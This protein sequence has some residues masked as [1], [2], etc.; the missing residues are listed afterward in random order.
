MG[1]A[2][3]SIYDSVK[4]F[5]HRGGGGA[6]DPLVDAGADAEE[7]DAG[8][9]DGERPVDGGAIA[10]SGQ[11]VVLL[12]DVHGL[13]DEEVVVKGYYRVDEG[14]E[15]YEVWPERGALVTANGCHEDEEFREHTS[16][17]RDASQGEEGQGHQQGQLRVGLVETVVGGH[18]GD[19]SAAIARR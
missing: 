10:E 8:G 19:A 7:E 18:L 9:A 5:L 2:A 15:H 4:R 1:S 12:G 17:G 11:W 3:V 13:D 6:V 16:E 14:D